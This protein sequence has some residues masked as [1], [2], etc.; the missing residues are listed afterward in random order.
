MRQRCRVGI[1]LLVLGILAKGLLNVKYFWRVP[2]W[3]YWGYPRGLRNHQKYWVVG[4]SRE[5]LPLMEACSCGILLHDAQGNL[6]SPVLDADMHRRGPKLL[7]DRLDL[8]ELIE[9]IA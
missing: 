2:M 6:F 3:T 8:G 1:H 5:R 9:F 4:G 7:E